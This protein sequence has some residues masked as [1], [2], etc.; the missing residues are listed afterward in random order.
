MKRTFSVIALATV[1]FA[2]MTTGA[3]ARRH[4]RCDDD[5]T[6]KHH[7]IDL[8]DGVLVIEHEY[9]D[10]TV[11]ITE[12]YE[13][14]VDGREIK[15]DRKQRKLLRRYYR[16]Y[17]EI[18]EIA[19]ELGREAAKVG[20]AGAKIGAAA[21]VRVAKTLLDDD[22]DC[23]DLEIDIEIDT[24]QIERMAEKIEKK[25][26]KIEGLADDLVKTHKRLRKS[27]PELRDLED[28]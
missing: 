13:L 26:E 2:V 24:A 5:W 8:D 7:E 17:E 6:L 14:Y 4:S 20:V 1:M 22:Y 10:W 9:E 23:D 15:T 27:I 12:D 18:E 19:E 21:V 25:A 11:E 16:D 28:F 3:E